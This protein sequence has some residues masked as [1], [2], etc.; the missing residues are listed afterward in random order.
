MS[1]VLS[2]TRRRAR[3]PGISLAIENRRLSDLI[4][5]PKNP[6]VHSRQQVQKIAKSIS[7]FGFNSPI[8]IDAQYRVLAGHGRL[9]AAVL[10]G[11]EFVPTIR[12]D[13][14]T[15]AQA[16]A[17][18]LTDNRLAELSSWDDAQLGEQ[19][20]LLIEDDLDFD[21]TATGFEI[22]EIDAL[23]LNE[24]ASPDAEEEET[25]VPVEGPAVT[26]LGDI[27]LT[28]D[29]RIL[30]GDALDPV[31]YARL[32]LGDKVALA[33]VDFPYNVPI[34][35]HV[36]GKGKIQHREFAMASGEMDPRQFRE[37][38]SRACALLVDHSVNGA[39]HYL[40][41][42]WRSSRLI[43]EAADSHYSELKNICIWNKETP[44]LGSF[45]RSQ[46]EFIFVYKVGTA[47]H[48]NHIQLGKYGRNRSNVWSYPGA[49]S[50]ARNGEDG[51][52]LEFHSTSKPP[53]MI[54]D[55]LLDAS[56]PRDLVLDSFAGAGTTLIAAERTGRFARCIEIDPHYVDTTIRRYQSLTKR[57]AVHETLQCTFDELQE[58]RGGERHDQ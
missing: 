2:A 14:L 51:N 19:L 20:R 36:G 45:Y 44:G 55:L 24:A 53:R 37:F 16:K 1:A 11:L 27:W 48:Q 38:L 21:L 17:F 13:H 49:N 25:V 3:A 23:I 18:L 46:N 32:L 57:A 56:S 40:F 22:A 6:R 8:L 28:G 15:P 29:H 47:P 26:R 42:D 41:M 35:G 5:N 9:E 30:C 58:Y 10:L 31:N 4:P 54:A 52:L 50:F 39:I 43:Q 33:A 34:H 7:S 12:L